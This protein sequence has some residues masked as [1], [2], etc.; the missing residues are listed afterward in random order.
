MHYI[1]RSHFTNSSAR[2]S[3]TCRCIWEQLL[4]CGYSQIC[5]ATMHEWEIG[6]EMQHCSRRAGEKAGCVFRG[7]MQG[8]KKE[9]LERDRI[10]EIDADQIETQL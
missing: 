5:Q 7:V 2:T 8:Q 9:G 4:R 10:T 3:R 1:L 6:R